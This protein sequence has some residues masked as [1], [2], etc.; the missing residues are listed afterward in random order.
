MTGDRE[1]ETLQ[2]MR[3]PEGVL[4]AACEPDRWWL[5][6]TPTFRVGH[7]RRPSGWRRFWQWA[8]LGWTWEA[9]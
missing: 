4:V 3:L 5:C 6:V 2:R 8:F 9:I 7:K 1:L